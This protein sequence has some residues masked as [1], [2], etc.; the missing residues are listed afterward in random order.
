[1]LRRNNSPAGFGIIVLTLLAA[2]V[3][4]VLGR[5]WL[6]TAELRANLELARGQ[7]DD[8]SRLQIENRRLQ[9]KQISA[10]E[11]ERLRADHAALPRLRAEVEAL[12]KAGESLAP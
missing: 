9:E 5:Q 12:K 10:T 2:V 3:L 1:M 11:L 8:V 6:T 7:N 4:L